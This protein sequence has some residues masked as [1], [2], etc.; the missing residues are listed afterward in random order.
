M[1]D[2]GIVYRGWEVIL[3][4]G[5]GQLRDGFLELVEIGKYLVI[6]DYILVIKGFFFFVIIDYRFYLFFRLQLIVLLR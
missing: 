1:V 4:Q 2:G 6:D 3:G 5:W